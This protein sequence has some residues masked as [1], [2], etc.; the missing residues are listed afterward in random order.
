[1]TICIASMCEGGRQVVVAADRMFTVGPPLNV[2]F[3]PPL[4]KI[5]PVGSRCVIL[6]SGNSLYGHEV[7]SRT[8]SKFEH[9][10][11][12]SV[13]LVGAA[14]Q[15]EYARFRDEVVEQNLIRATFG[16]DFEIFKQRGGFL[17]AYLQAQPGIYQGIVAQ[18][19]QY[20]I[21]LDFIASGVDTAG[22]HIFY[23]GHPGVLLNFDKLGHTAIGSGA[24]HAVVGLSL[25]KQTPQSS[26]METLY[27]VYAAKR[28]AEVAPGVGADT[29]MAI[30]SDEGIWN[31]ND[32]II[33]ALSAQHA[34]QVQKQKPD[35][36][37]VKEVY[38]G[39]RKTG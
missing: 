36:T 38:N 34:E 7:V 32:A 18:T 9:G 39:Q 16:N 8:R 35:L 19:S 27:A 10:K 3:E 13:T 37:K 20:N 6:S 33:E 22:G 21:T 1:M 5:D 2:E 4:T 29:E 11:T 17:P 25:N 28:S 30:I 23:V 12:V 24:V 31:C 15:A 26:L 14:L